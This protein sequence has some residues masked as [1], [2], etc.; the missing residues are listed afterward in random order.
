[1]KEL[2]AQV[3]QL[4]QK[5]FTVARTGGE[6][7]GWVL[8]GRSVGCLPGAR[9]IEGWTRE[10]ALWHNAGKGD[11]EGWFWG[12]VICLA[13]VLGAIGRLEAKHADSSD[14]FL[15]SHRRLGTWVRAL[16]PSLAP[17]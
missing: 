11:G 6:V 14:P 4:Q 12:K 7:N 13:V 17:S 15:W 1:L 9:L 5:A 8:V 3:L 2:N 16:P 10:D